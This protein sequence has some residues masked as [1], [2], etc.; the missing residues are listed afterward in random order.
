MQFDHE[1]LSYNE[2]LIAELSE[3]FVEATQKKISA[4]THKT[5]Q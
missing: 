2:A 5:L 4:L 3:Q 1:M